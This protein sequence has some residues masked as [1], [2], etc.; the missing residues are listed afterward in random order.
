MESSKGDMLPK[1]YTLRCANG[2][3]L[4]VE[5]MQH[6]MPRH[7]SQP[8]K[9]E[10]YAVFAPCLQSREKDDFRAALRPV[11][12]SDKGVFALAANRHK[13]GFEC[14]QDTLL[15]RDTR[16]DPQKERPGV[17]GSGPAVYFKLIPFE[18]SDR[19]RAVL[20]NRAGDGKQDMWDCKL[21]PSNILDAGR[22]VYTGPDCS[23]QIHQI[24]SRPLF[25]TYR[26]WL[27]VDNFIEDHVLVLQDIRLN[28]GEVETLQHVWL[29]GQA[30]PVVWYAG[31]LVEG[32]LKFAIYKIH[33]KDKAKDASFIRESLRFDEHRNRLNIA[34]N[35]AEHVCN[36]ICKVEVPHGW[37]SNKMSTILLGKDEEMGRLPCQTDQLCGRTLS[38]RLDEV[39]HSSGNRRDFDGFGFHVTCVIEKG[40]I[41]GGQLRLTKG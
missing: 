20:I 5:L 18:D 10:E 17:G 13:H 6:R 23:A 32:L 15:T 33:S 37:L 7:G 25:D 4:G 19:I 12:D 39:E 27:W 3:Y 8:Q 30:H 1:F 40:D 31:Y 36:L 28:D 26:C 35:V 38:G 29:S 21:E 14:P 2:E 34:P 11:F 22:L 9:Y 41:T 16:H 24:A